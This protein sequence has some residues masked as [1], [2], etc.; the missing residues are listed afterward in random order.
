MTDEQIVKPSDRA[1]ENPPDAESP[2]TLQRE[3]DDLQ[4]RLLRVTAEYDNYRKRTDRERR[5][6][7]DAVAGDFARDLL[8][9]L[10]DLE[11]ALA[12]PP[13]PGDQALR[14]GV[15]LIHRQLVDALRR[16]NITPFE[17][18]GQQFD[19]SWHEALSSEAAPGKPDG[20]ILSEVR[21]GYRVG[22]RLLRPALV[23]VAKA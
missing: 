12:A 20:E 2:E 17:S 19:P 1:S 6:L 8:P 23:L 3:R 13:Q 9:A 10:D 16:R 22:S 11:R 5:E 4:D 15:E 7:S 18:V 14:A 21:R